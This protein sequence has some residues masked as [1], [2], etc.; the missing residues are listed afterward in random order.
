MA[1]TWKSLAS[2]QLPNAKGTL[3]TAPGQVLVN[4]IIVV[5]PAGAARTVNLY[6]KQSAGTS[7]RIIPPNLPMDSSDSTKAAQIEALDHPLELSAGDLIEGDA[8]VATAV[9]YVITG[10][11][12]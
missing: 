2:G 9:D 4:S 7:K 11:E 1:V 3:Y 5:E 8:N 10:A 6:V 12:R